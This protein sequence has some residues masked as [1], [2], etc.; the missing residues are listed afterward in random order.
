L[1]VRFVVFHLEPLLRTCFFYQVLDVPPCWF[2]VFCSC[3]PTISYGCCCKYPGCNNWY[4][5]HKS[6]WGFREQAFFQ[7]S[8]RSHSA[9]NLEGYLDNQKQKT[10]S[11]GHRAKMRR[12]KWVLFS[13]LY[14]GCLKIA[15]TKKNCG[16]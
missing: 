7:V 2:F 4:I 14:T 9:P 15:S 8:E 12:L 5:L 1:G 3:E 6:S 13:F 16:I 11:E 10:I